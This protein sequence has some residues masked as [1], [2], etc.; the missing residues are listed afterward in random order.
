MNLDLKINQ[1]FKLLYTNE[2][3]KYREFI[4][5]GGRGGAKTYEMK[6]FLSIKALT[7]KCNILCLREFAN[8]NKNSLLSEFKEFIEKYNIEATLKEYIILGKKETAIKISVEEICFKHNGSRIIFAGINDNTAMALKSISNIKY[9]WVEEASF[10]SEYSYRILKPTIRVENSKIFFTFNPQ[11]EDDFIYQKA[12]NNKSEKVY[13]KKVN[14]DTNAFF[15]SV[16]ELDRQDDFNNLPSEMYN[17]IWLGEPL[18][19]NEFQ[20]INTNIIGYFDDNLDYSYSEIILVCDTASSVKEHA[21]YSVI[22]VFAKFKDD[23]H[24]I[25]IYRSRI[26]FNELMDKIKEVYFYISEK[27]NL[28][29][30]R[31]IIEKKSSGVSLVEEFQ[32]FTRL[33]IYPIIPKTDKVARVEAVL[34]EFSKLKLPL[35]K[36][37]P[38]NSW[39]DIYLNELKNFRGDMEHKHD[40]Q[41]D[42]T[43]YA[44][45]YFKKNVKI[46]WSKFYN[47]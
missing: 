26:L 42:V 9:C 38:I 13:V 30:S 44:L 4:F 11:K 14:Y 23:I 3:N 33:P 15:P 20:L 1:D 5:F 16:L 36:N 39:V 46:Q 43:A 24:L 7:E 8:K 25:R 32:R 41:V 40:D 12:I 27:Y 31:V 22:G 17:H 35:N 21:D 28:T 29:P 10:I 47:I 18:N 19:Y 37:N 34:S 6:Q 2:I 45:D